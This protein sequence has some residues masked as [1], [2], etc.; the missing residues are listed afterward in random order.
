MPLR[1]HVTENDL[2]A[3][4]VAF[5]LSQIGFKLRRCKN[6]A[7]PLRPAAQVLCL[8]FDSRARE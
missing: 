1:G 7:G 5:S 4:R 3:F 6:F 2:P 8:V